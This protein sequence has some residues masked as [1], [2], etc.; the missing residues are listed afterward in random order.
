MLLQRSRIVRHL[1]DDWGRLEST[2]QVCQ[3]KG[4]I[5]ATSIAEIRTHNLDSDREAV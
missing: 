1:S 3:P 2:Y 4:E 5:D